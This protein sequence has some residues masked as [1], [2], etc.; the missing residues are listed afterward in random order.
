[1][2]TITMKLKTTEIFRRF[3]HLSIIGQVPT[4]AEW[5]QMELVL[6]ETY[7]RFHD[8]MHEH[9]FQLTDKEHKTCLLIR[10]GFKP[11]AIS[12]MLGTSAAYIS[13]VRSEMMKKLFGCSM[14]L[15]E[16]D[17]RIQEMG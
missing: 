14:Q 2:K 17:K 6:Y 10:M 15:R 4:S 13:I 16:F 3:E 9:R 12:H 5:E 8:F 11:S 1:M 7:S